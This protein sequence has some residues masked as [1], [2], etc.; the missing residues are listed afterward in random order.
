VA[1]PITAK[2]KKRIHVRILATNRSPSVGR[3]Y[4]CCMDLS[5][6]RTDHGYVVIGVFN[7]SAASVPFTASQ[8]VAQPRQCN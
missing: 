6:T 2:L 1:T 5:R 4:T 8:W 7:A 3:C